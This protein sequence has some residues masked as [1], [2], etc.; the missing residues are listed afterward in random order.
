MIAETSMLDLT[1]NEN[2]DV[3][4]V[5]VNPGCQLK[6]FDDHNNF[7][8]L[9]S[10]VANDDFCNENTNN[11]ECR[12]INDRAS[13]LSCTCLTGRVEELQSQKM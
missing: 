8:L 11:A 13:S 6:L 12:D 9:D 7:G 10:F 4:S 2:N 3:T 5:R 1:G